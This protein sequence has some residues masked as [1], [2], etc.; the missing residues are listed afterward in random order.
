MAFYNRVKTMKNAPIG[1]IMPWGGNSTLRGSN[2]PNVPHGWILCDGNTH[3]AQDYPLLASM[4]GN[5]YGPSDTAIKG[6]FPDYEASDTFRVPDLNG[7][8]MVDVERSMLLES[9]YQYNQPDANNV[10]GNLIDGDG[11]AVTPP[12][13]YLSLIHI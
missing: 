9:K 8:A 13:I 2:P 4:I 11:T 12:A 7:R 3:P 1:T 6:Q 5:T 10:V